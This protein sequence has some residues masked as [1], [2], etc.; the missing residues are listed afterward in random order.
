MKRPAHKLG[1]AS[2]ASAGR[3]LRSGTVPRSMGTHMKTT[4][5]IADPLLEQAKRE[6]HRQGTTLRALVER[7]LT[8]VVHGG[9]TDRAFVLRDASISGEGATEDWRALSPDERVASM[10]EE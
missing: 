5:D 9:G 6:A 3:P 4:I 1:P 10:Y 7:G 2:I 8:L